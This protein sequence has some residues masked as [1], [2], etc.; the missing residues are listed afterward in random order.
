MASL[1]ITGECFHYARLSSRDKKLYTQIYKGLSRQCI[2]FRFP[3]IAGKEGYPSNDHIL[4]IF[5]HVI[6]DHPEMYYVDATNL[7]ITQHANPNRNIRIQ[8]TDY[9]PQELRQE[10]EEMLRMR[11]DAILDR[12][13]PK[14]DKFT[15]LCCLYQSLLEN[16]RYMDDI[17]KENTLKNLEAR[18]IIGPLL[19][20]LSVCSGYAKTFKLLCDQIGIG[21]FYIRGSG[22]GDNGWGNHGWNVVYLDKKFY[23]VDITFDIRSASA[24]DIGSW[25]Y[26]LKSDSVMQKNHRW[27]RNYFPV[28]LENYPI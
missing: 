19:N 13:P 4:E 8:Y 7:F 27:N 18:T 16:V 21:C 28:I 24:N 15:Q 2:D 3:A 23:H 25:H 6:W 20:H 11:L 22:L 1:F 12:I 9:F 14:A 26:F 5:L 10:I 17:S